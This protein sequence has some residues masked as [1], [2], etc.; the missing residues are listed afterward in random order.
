M[1]ILIVNYHYFIHGGPD[2]YFFNIKDLLEKDGHTVIPFS[3]NYDETYETP[4]RQFFP[5]PITGH[6][7]FLLENLKLSFFRKLRLIKYMFCNKEVEK[8]FIEILQSEQPDIIY[9]IYLSSSMLPK[10]FHIAKKQFGIPI[11]YRLSDFHMFCPSYLF[12]RDGIT[13]Q[14]CLTT[15]FSAIKHKCVQ[16]SVVASFLRVFQIAM[17]RNKRWY[18][19]VDRFLCPS[20]IMQEVLLKTGFT[21]E[22]LHHV[23]TFASDLQGPQ[24]TASPYILYFGKLSREKGVEV[25]LEAYNKLKFPKFPLKLIGPCS[26]SYKVYLLSLVDELHREKVTISNS[27]QGES[28]WQALRDSAFIVHPALWL[29]NMPN[30]LIEAL[31][32]GKP[33]V[34]SSIGSL[35]ELVV[36]GENGLL[37]EPGNALELARALEWMS[38]EAVLIAM[39]SCARERFLRDHTAQV[40]LQKLLKIFRELLA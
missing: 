28:L 31:S 32:A 26:D 19:N 37:V 20:R 17:I 39:G 7:S 21:P 14:E 15:P 16:S 36:D 22:R 5:A 29:E 9:S 33:V 40:H 12:Y 27:L 18:D 3:F 23:P 2:R 25:L 10:I 24:N 30:S 11:V 38:R 34:A 4:F 6:G 13:C 1:K 35:T 8:K